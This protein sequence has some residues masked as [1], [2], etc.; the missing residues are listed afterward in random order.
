[1]DVFALTP[2]W[3]FPNTTS[4]K[5]VDG[6]PH[7]FN[8]INTPRPVPDSCTSSIV[9]GGRAFLL[10]EPCE[11]LHTST[12]TFKSF[13]LFSITIKLPHSNLALYN[14]YRQPQSSTK[15]QHYMAFSQFQKAFKTLISSVST[16]YEF[17]TTGDFKIHVADRTDSNAIQFLSLLDRANLT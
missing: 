13:E 15:S 5:L 1:M 8:F 7:G 16:S 6:I 17:L 10:R 12:I 11:L 2:I 3:I 4:A 14:I 9:G